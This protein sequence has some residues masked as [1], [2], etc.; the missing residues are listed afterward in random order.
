MVRPFIKWAGG[1]RWLVSNPAF[2]IPCFSGR[3]IEP[4]LGGGAIF[5]YLEPKT[6]ILTDVNHRLIET[7]Q[8]VRDNW[9]KVE[10]ELKRLQNRHSFQF[11]YEE[12]K[13]VRR[14][15]H[16]RAA[17]FLYL[18]R[19]CFNGLYRENLKGKF[20]V[21]IGDKDR[22][23]FEDEDFGKI[24]QVLK[25]AKIYTSDF[26]KAIDQ[27][28][29]GD[30]VFVDPPYNTAHNVN[31]FIKY[32]QQ[33]FSW[34]DQVRLQKAIFRAAKRGAK[35]LLTNADHDSIWKLYDGMEEYHAIERKS[36]IASDS[37][38]RRSTTEAIYIIP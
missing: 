11:Y 35:I 33:I 32:N 23:I 17:Q 10:K 18:N 24:S 13:R 34:Q 1:K 29:E 30:L 26:E 20:N 3:Y 36:V 5:F 8:G 7:Y 31:G 25:S 12:R 14:L 21:P 2:D 6:A 27:A 19:T 37:R 4:I 15:P 16:M 22:I 38:Y 28:D 9:I